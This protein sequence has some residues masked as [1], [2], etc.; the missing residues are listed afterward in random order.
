MVQPHNLIALVTILALLTYL[1]TAINVAR[2]RRAHGIAPPAMTGAPKVEQALRVQANTLEWLAI[3]LP[4]LWLFAVYWSDLVAA[5]LGALW[6]VGRL[7]Y[8]FGYMQEKVT[9]RYPGFGI[10]GVA[11][12]ILM[13]GALI[14]AIRAL[15]VTGG[16]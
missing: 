10:Q 2:N 6:V 14:G 16:V 8:G 7:L 13:I 4:A 5:V 1:G 11:T 12:F 15:M 3:F 9:A